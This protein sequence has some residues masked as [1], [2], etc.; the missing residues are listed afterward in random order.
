MM[1]GAKST[2]SSARPTTVSVC[3]RIMRVI[4]V[5]LGVQGHKRRKFAGADFVAAVDPFNTDAQYR[6]V[7]DVPLD[8]YDAALACI[9]DEP[10]IE[11]LSYLLGHGKH[12]LVEK[13]LW[14]GRDA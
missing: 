2:R 11:I 4:V 9:P 8:C 1:S 6:K 12:V 13:P 3:S 5:G 10:K 14:A 7:E